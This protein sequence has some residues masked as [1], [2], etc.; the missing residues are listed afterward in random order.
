MIKTQ[1]FLNF[2]KSE[3]GFLVV[4][5]ILILVLFTILSPKI[6][7][8]LFPFKRQNILT[9]FIKNT[10]TSGK[11]NGQAYWKFREF[12]SPGYFTFSRSGINDSLSRKAIK[13][14]GISY[15]QKRTTLTFLTY[16]SSRLYSLDIL[17]KQSNLS[18][19]FDQRSIKKENIIFNGEN[20]IIY[21]EDSKK[22]KIVFLISNFEMKKANGFFDYQEK[23]KSLVEGENWF[24]V[25]TIN[26]D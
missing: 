18:K 24:N 11:I 15:D 4:I 17:T 8:L 6:S 16:S 14:I 13:E 1:R 9:E 7:S 25:T 2:F 19:I 23:D 12:Y 21:E 26:K 22:I 20:G 5:L 3:N 10:K